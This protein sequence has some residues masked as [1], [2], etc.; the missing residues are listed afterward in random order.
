MFNPQ[1]LK[2]E[3]ERTVGERLKPTIEAAEK[4]KFKAEK[5]GISTSSSFETISRVVTT[6]ELRC[7]LNS[8]FSFHDDLAKI[9]GLALNFAIGAQVLLGALTTALGAAL[10]GKSVSFYSSIS[11]HRLH[12]HHL[13]LNDVP[14]L[15]F[16]QFFRPKPFVCWFQ[17]MSICPAG[18]RSRLYILNQPNELRLIPDIGL[19]LFNALLCRN[20]GTIC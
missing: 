5:K 1:T 3:K 2:F 8:P 15:L 17:H 18:R 7:S 14:C 11:H 9:T 6:L 4:E 10:T 12:H 20:Y 19:M 16:C 13:C